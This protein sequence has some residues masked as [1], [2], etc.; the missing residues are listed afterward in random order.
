VPSVA[1]ISSATIASSPNGTASE[2]LKGMRFLPL[3]GL[4]ASE[5]AAGAAIDG[6][7]RISGE[8]NT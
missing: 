2:L 1:Y 6:N 7:C 5:R 3:F 4:R 8:T